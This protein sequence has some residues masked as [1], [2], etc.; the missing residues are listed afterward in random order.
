MSEKIDRKSKKKTQEQIWTEKLKSSDEQEF[1]QAIKEIRQ[2]GSVKMLPVLIESYGSMADGERKKKIFSLLTDI[3]HHEA[4]DIIFS[5]VQNP[6]YEH[7]QKDL[8]SL[9]WQSRLDFSA[10]AEQLVD[11]FITKP[12]ALAFE[13]FTALEYMEHDVE[14]QIA[15]RCI[16]KLK[17]SLATIDEQ[18]RFLLVDLVHILEKWAG[19]SEED[20]N[21]F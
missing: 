8:L 13:A 18:K 19:K 16:R 9:L 6:S 12:F 3:K 5:Y 17:Q 14:P 1:T 10:Y 7:I 20:L 15:V 2:F 4:A 11:M 21:E